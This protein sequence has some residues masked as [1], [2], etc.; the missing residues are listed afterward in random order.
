MDSFNEIFWDS[1]SGFAKPVSAVKLQVLH[2][3]PIKK[4]LG[5]RWTRLSPLVHRLFEKALR[6]AQGPND[7]FVTDGELS[8]VASFHDLCAEEASLACCAVAQEVCQQLFGETS[9]AVSFRNVVGTVPGP[10]THTSIRSVQL[11]TFLEENGTE[12]VFTCKPNAARNERE[13]S[14]TGWIGYSQDRAKQFG[15]ILGFCPMWDL[16]KKKSQWLFTGIGATSANNRAI[17]SIQRAIG[18]NERTAELELNALQAAAEYGLK[19]QDARQIC[20][21]TVGVSYETLSGFNS[22][23]RYIQFLKALIVS[24]TCPLFIKIEQIPPGAPL[25][26]LGE[27]IAM[28]TVPKVRILLEFDCAIPPLDLKLGIVGIGVYLPN[29]CPANGVRQ[30]SQLLKYR[31]SEQKAFAFLENLADEDQLA[32][33]EDCGIK[34]GIGR[35]F[36]SGAFLAGLESI[37]KFPLKLNWCSV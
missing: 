16:Q 1:A 24:P 4:R 5:E 2:L 3:D 22:R 7:H 13:R 35:G 9:E 15:L 19:V 32:V 25:C 8:Y 27:I 11:S 36:G 33:A 20:A 6:K 37:P 18:R 12:T 30:L 14:S 26:R 29:D 28:I 34:F 31:A 21:I 10:V 23:I 17:T